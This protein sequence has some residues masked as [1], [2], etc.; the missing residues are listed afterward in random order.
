MKR[1]QWI[2][3]APAV[4]A[5][6]MVVTGDASAKVTDTTHTVFDTSSHPRLSVKNINGDLIVEGWNK[7]TIEVTAVKTAKNQEDLDNVQIFSEKNGDRVA[8]R[9]EYKH[10][11]DGRS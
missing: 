1:L 3:L 4:V 10:D 9:V 7:N 5:L 11:H 8:I 6:S 2:A